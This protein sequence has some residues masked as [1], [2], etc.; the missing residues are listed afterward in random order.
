[1]E[2]RNSKFRKFAKFRKLTF[3]RRCGVYMRSVE[4]SMA[5]NRFLLI[6]RDLIL[7]SSVDPG[8]PSLAAAPDAP[9]TWPPLS[10]RA[11]SIISFSWEASVRVSSVRLFGS[12]ARG[13]HE[14]QL[15]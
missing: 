1:M 5:L 6:L 12:L 4:G 7:D 15:S 11:A 10:H 2:S 8:I 3:W 14:S 13:C 9:E